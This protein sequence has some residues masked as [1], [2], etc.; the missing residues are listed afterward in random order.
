MVPRLPEG[1]TEFDRIPIPTP[2]PL[3][4]AVRIGVGTTGAGVRP[5]PL[6]GPSRQAWDEPCASCLGIPIIE[7]R[8]G[9]VKANLGPLASIVGEP[10]KT[11]A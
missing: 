5:G 7:G 11:G 9:A 8:E 10:S 4:Q 1:S 6:R 2:T 3:A